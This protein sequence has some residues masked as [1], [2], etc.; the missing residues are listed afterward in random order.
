[1]YIYFRKIKKKIQRKKILHKPNCVCFDAQGYEAALAPSH[2][3]DINDK[4]SVSRSKVY[5][6]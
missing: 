1:M 2:G 6:D 4:D 3:C 5:L